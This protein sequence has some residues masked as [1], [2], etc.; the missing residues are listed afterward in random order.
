[1]TRQ[2]ADWAGKAY[3][4]GR[5]VLD[6]IAHSGDVAG[7]DMAP[8]FASVVAACALLCA[9]VSA[10]SAADILPTKAPPTRMESYAPPAETWTGETWTGW[11]GGV[12]I[13]YAHGDVR[14]G[15]PIL[16]VTDVLSPS[17][18]VATL[19]GGVDYQFANN[20]VIGARVLLPFFS[21]S[22]SVASGG[23][24]YK[25]KVKRAILFAGRLGYSFGRFMPYVLGGGVWGRGEASVAGV[26]GVVAVEADHTGYIVGVGVEYRLFHNW[27]I[28]GAYHYVSMEKATYNFIPFG[29]VPVIY[30]YDSHAFTVGA[31]Y[32][33]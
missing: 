28:D 33:F 15:T 6:C 9:L 23:L 3:V 12:S 19:V 4:E 32:R 16:T 13:G 7:G 5:L 21:L 31:N 8:K 1:M 29:G 10:S 18:F 2:I 24:T 17:S 11:Y 14:R 22:D 25:G 30:G 27:S 20:V 26:P